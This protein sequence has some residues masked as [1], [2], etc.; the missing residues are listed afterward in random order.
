M[1]NTSKVNWDLATSIF[2]PTAKI[3]VASFKTVTV[4]AVKKVGANGTS[5]AAGKEDEAKGKAK[6]GRKRK[7]DF[8]GEREEGTA[9]KLKGGEKKEEVEVQTE[10]EEQNGMFV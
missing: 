8:D 3:K 2:D 9:K 1:S 5:G 6:G 4:K 7:V 10:A